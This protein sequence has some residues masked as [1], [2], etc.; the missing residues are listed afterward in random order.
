[1]TTTQKLQEELDTL[2]GI[3]ESIKATG[4]PRTINDLISL[5]DRINI[6]LINVS[7]QPVTFVDKSGHAI[8]T[9]K[10]TIA[11]AS[12]LF[13]IDR[14]S[15]LVTEETFQS[16]QLILPSIKIVGGWPLMVAVPKEPYYRGDTPFTKELIGY[17]W[18]AL[19]NIDFKQK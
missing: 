17:K 1:M 19:H 2:K 4:G 13:K 3:D 9:Y 18:I 7:G 15:W 12:T 8:V 14:C 11:A 10:P 6:K 16:L 5:L